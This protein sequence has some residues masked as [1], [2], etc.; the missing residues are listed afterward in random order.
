MRTLSYVVIDV[1]TD[2]ALAGNP[3][4]VFTDARGLPA[5]LMQALA[6]ELHLSETTFVLPASSKAAHA[7]VRIF[8]PEAELPFAGHPTLGTAFVLGQPM[9]V[10]LINL[11]TGAGVIP[12]RLEREGARVTFGWMQQPVAQARPLGEAFTPVGGTDPVAALYE[13]LRWPASGREPPVFYDN[14]ARHLLVA[15]QSA[16]QVA[17]LSPD[18]ARLAALTTAGCL[19][20]A[21]AEG[22]T[23]EPFVK[24]RL[25]GPGLGV[26]EDPATGSAAG[27]LALHLVKLGR[28]APGI[29]LRIEQGAEI[30]RPS[31]LYATVHAP[32]GNT[33]QAEVEVGG[34]AVVVARGQFQFHHLPPV[35]TPR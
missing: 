24:A 23:Q 21:L 32:A 28:L 2:R 10:S 19:V 34:A 22:G 27:P 35:G 33:A 9:Q 3:L 30:H 11:E 31:T 25:F 13:A 16:A 5:D 8:T 18:F 15:A 6:R 4:A 1:F 14:G 17:A 29:T 26:P 20:Y 7:R 12:V